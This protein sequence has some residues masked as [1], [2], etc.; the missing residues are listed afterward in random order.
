MAV[1]KWFSIL[2]VAR[3][4]CFNP[5]LMHRGSFKSFNSYH[6]MLADHRKEVLSDVILSSSNTDVPFTIGVYCDVHQMTRPGIYCLSKIKSIHIQMKVWATETDLS[7]DSDFDI[8]FPATGVGS[9]STPLTSTLLHSVSMDVNTSSS[10]LGTSEERSFLR[11]EIDDAF[12]LSERVDSEK[13]LSRAAG[14]K[15]FKARSIF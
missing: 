14:L 7:P 5:V 15:R 2:I 10:L 1:G 9:S 4:N 6:F 13:E 3:M 12:K 8:D 11:H